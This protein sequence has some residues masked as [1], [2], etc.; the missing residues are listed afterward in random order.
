M[1][2]SEKLT[3]LYRSIGRHIRKAREGQ[4]ITLEE[5]A[6]K[7]GRDWTFLSQIE[8]AKSIPS[9]ETLFLICEQLRVPLATLFDSHK[10]KIPN[11]NDPLIGKIAY[12]MK[13]ASPKDKKTAVLLLKKLF[14]K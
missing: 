14:N 2:K 7:S 4:G 12:L 9:I 8:L 1:G 5:L 13:D 10:T 6:D 3:N 11:C